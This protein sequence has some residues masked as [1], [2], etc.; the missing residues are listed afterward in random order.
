M[1]ALAAGSA[2]A[3]FAPALRAQAWPVRPLQLVIPWPPGGVTDFVGRAVADR[4]GVQL[5]QRIVVENRAGATG[6][7]GSEFAARAA[8]DGYSMLM[9][10]SASH[11]IP[12]AAGVPLAYS[13]EKDFAP[14]VHLVSGGVALLVNPSL[15][16]STLAELVAL[17]RARPG[18][19]TVA[20]PG[21]G[22]VSHL[23]GE[24]LK[25][26]AAVDMRTVHYRGEAPAVTDVLGG[27]IDMI[28]VAG[29][30]EHVEAGRLKAIA[31]STDRRSLLYPNV[32]T[33]AESGFA[34]FNVFG[35]NG[36]VVPVRTPPEIVQKLNAAANAALSS[37]E[38]RKLLL[39]RG[40]VPVGGTPQQFGKLL[41]DETEQWRQ[42]FRY[43]KITL[44]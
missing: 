16:V 19:L 29:G 12:V 22:T 24:M 11:T 40:L 3:V 43:A 23:T 2:A 34:D 14:V 25:K 21:A 5:G 32:P 6:R 36:F 37:D 31:T 8:P 33:V 44:E 9:A 17:A 13:P 42:L 27:H 7:I 4:M 35:W 15:N 28:W 41:R 39:E 38:V 30:R 1:S 26:A 20:S 10:I 18:A